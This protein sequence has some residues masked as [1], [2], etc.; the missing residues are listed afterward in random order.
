[1][2]NNT[3]NEARHDS[4]GENT[5][6]M[7][8]FSSNGIEIP[9][10]QRDYVQGSDMQAEKRD[11][12]ID[13]LFA[14][15]ADDDKQCEL[16]FI[17]G[18]FEHGAFIPLDGQQRLTTLYLLHWFLMN[19]CRIVAQEEYA[20]ITAGF[21]FNANQF[22][23]K[24]RRSSTAFCQKLAA[25]APD[26]FSGEIS[27]DIKKQTWFSEDWQQDPS[28]VAM[29][30]MLDALNKKADQFADTDI[31]R[32]LR[33]LLC[34][35]AINF[36]KL[37]MESYQL[38]DSLYV[39]MNAR[40]KQLTEFEN[41]KA[42][43]ILYLEENFSGKPY[44]NAESDRATDFGSVNDYFTHSIEHEWTD[45]FWTYAVDDYKK[46]KADYDSKNSDERAMSPEPP[47]P[48]VDGF[49]INFYYYIYRMLSFLSAASVD[50]NDSDADHGTEATRKELFKVE[51]NIEFLFGALDMFVN[52]Q[53]SN[54]GGVAG[55]FDELFYLDGQKTDGSVR[56]F[57]SERTDLFLTCVTKATVD[58][59]VLLFC[60][61]KY[62]M[63]HRCYT[64]TDLLKKYVRVCRNLLE[65]ITQRLAKDM[66]IHSNVRLSQ[67]SRYAV[68]IDSLCSVA[69]IATLKEFK[70]GMGDVASV[71]SWMLKYPDADV[72]RLEDSGYT[73]GS[74]YAF[75]DGT[76]LADQVAAFDAFKS[77]SDLERSRVL[78]AFGYKGADFGW[79][80]HGSRRFF[81]YKDRWDA[82]FRY[83][84]EADQLRVA[85]G[86]FTVAYKQ[87]QSV[88]AVIA[89][90]LQA[91]EA[92][93]AGLAGFDVF[94]YYYLKYDTFANSSLHWIMDGKPSAADVDAHHFFAIY[95]DNYY[96]IVTLPRFSSNPLLGYNTEPYSCA[97][98]QY[99]R[100]NDPDVYAH[101]SYTG[102]DRN[103]ACLTFNDNNVSFESTADGWRIAFANDEYSQQ[104]GRLPL[105]TLRKIANAKC[106]T[107]KADGH[108]I[109]V[110]GKDRIEEAVYVID[111][112]YH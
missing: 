49:F 92:N 37:D 62:C 103:R 39:K 90:R 85:F 25:Y 61:V 86:A 11:A 91:L 57:S 66:M 79:C 7:E 80:A 35:K 34:T 43:F 33:R 13:S 65:T 19:K 26:V 67:L 52:I 47:G 83:R 63:R 16:D 69:D 97:V 87:K 38:T 5:N 20:E 54:N 112:M 3:N 30:D 98:A 77:A 93:V 4:T 41:W 82:I 36:D 101:L 106:T 24:T 73:H 48:L 72:Y 111:I 22:T 107:R 12:F 40:G 46:R 68:T 51:G 94:E 108:Y 9:L 105:A 6:F 89:D 76:A 31:P 70:P 71:Y 28:V 84:D 29:L 42:K 45:L 81:G 21:N 18:T 74:L 1:M 15:L 109:S 104:K 64:A 10:I 100:H 55:F 95:P 27:E 110:G 56:L 53:R 58:E 44:S 99:F 60:I 23:Y 32:M 8:F 78:V 88:A 102:K 17:Y 96:D 59:Q 50:S 14:A 75:S 2:E